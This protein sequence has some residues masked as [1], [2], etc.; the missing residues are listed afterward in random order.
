MIQVTPKTKD[1]ARCGDCFLF[2]K[3]TTNPHIGRCAFYRA[4]FHVDF[5]CFWFDSAEKRESQA[6]KNS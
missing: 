3:Y 1:E 4:N 2:T 6:G 5:G